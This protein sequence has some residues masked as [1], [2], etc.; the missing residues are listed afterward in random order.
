MLNIRS[1]FQSSKIQ[2]K[3]C[4]YSQFCE[5]DEDQLDIGLRDAI[6]IRFPQTRT[7]AFYFIFLS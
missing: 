7:A 1:F 5:G 2:F 4:Y 6:N 3:N